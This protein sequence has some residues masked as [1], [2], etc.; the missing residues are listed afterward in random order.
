MS[1]RW[2]IVFNVSKE[3]VDKMLDRLEKEHY[4]YCPICKSWLL[5]LW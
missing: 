5:V 1:L 3:R 2:I 4:E